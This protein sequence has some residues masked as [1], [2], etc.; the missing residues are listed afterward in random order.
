MLGPEFDDPPREFSLCPFWFW[1]DDLDEAELR[2]QMDDFQTH[3]V[4]AFVIHPR[5]GLPR[6]LGW[7][8][9]AL[10]RIMRF[11]VEEAARRGMGVVLYDEGMYPSGSSSGQVVA[12]DPRYRCRGL[13]RR[14]THSPPRDPDERLL[15]RDDEWEVVE[16]PIASTVRGLHYVGEGPE[17]DAPPAADLLNPDAMRCFIRRVYD[18]YAEV[19]G[20]HFG[21][22]IRGIFTDEPSL[23]GRPREAG[24]LP[25]TV[26]ILDHVH[27]LTGADL[28][29]NLPELWDEGSEARR[30]YE[31]GLRQRLAETYYAPL[32]D[33]CRRHGIALM[34]HPERPDDL[35][36]LRF[37]DVPGQDLVWRWVLPGPTALE[38]PQSTQA[39]AAASAMA[40]AG[41]RR[42]SNECAGAYGHELTF[43]EFR[44]LIDWCIVRGT[45]LFFP[46]AFYYS[47]RG[48]RRDERPP[49]VGPNSPWWD[50]FADL[51]RYAARLCWLNTDSEHIRR[52]AILDNDGN[53]PWRAAR[54]CFRHQIDFDYL[55][56]EDLSRLR[57]RYDVVVTD[58]LPEPSADLAYDAFAS[59]PAFA[60]ALAARVGRT[61]DVES[62]PDLRVRHVRKAGRDVF[63]VHN[64]GESSLNLAL[65]GEFTRLDPRDL[66]EQRTHRLVLNPFELTLLLP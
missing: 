64:E 26:D 5:V 18:R 65:P 24:L 52:V 22:T 55:A 1:N 23:L 8:S 48:P 31:R 11:V 66:T 28:R 42:I 62:H 32:S 38:G 43:I 63:I 30:V 44:W 41:Q 10:L 57:L 54:A 13:E 2:R 49:D 58:G 56:R 20:D 25:G 47:V 37:F 53:L 39:K 46:H 12:E 35:A 17:E 36:A 3:G 40:A 4:H 61:L 15:F 9:D 14:P 45:N 60:Q 51:A 19:L 34:G 6:S 27:R 21:T 7:M 29:P 59:D 33:W 50:R 16:R